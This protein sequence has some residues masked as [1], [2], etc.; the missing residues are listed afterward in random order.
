MLTEVS[1]M[2]SGLGRLMPSV[3]VPTFFAKAER[4]KGAKDGQLLVQNA[5]PLESGSSP[6]AGVPLIALWASVYFSMHPLL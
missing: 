2:L 4:G 6:L 3:P 1:D 5:A